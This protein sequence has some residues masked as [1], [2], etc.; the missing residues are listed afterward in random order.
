[1]LDIYCKLGLFCCSPKGLNLRNRK[2]RLR[3]SESERRETDDAE[4]QGL[5]TEIEK[6]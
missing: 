4:E 5:P 3:E 2:R 6:A 1:M